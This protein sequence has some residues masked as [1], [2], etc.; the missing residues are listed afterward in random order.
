VGQRFFFFVF[1]TLV[2]GIQT[3]GFFFVSTKKESE[4]AVFTF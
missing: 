4:F 1:S 2:S 3:L